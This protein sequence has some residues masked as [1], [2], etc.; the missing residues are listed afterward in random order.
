[1]SEGEKRYKPTPEMKHILDQAW[2]WVQSVPYQT[3]ARWVFYRLLQDGTYTLK[4]HYH[5]LLSLLSRAR[6]GFYQ[7]W[8]PG[9]LADDTRAPVL[10]ERLG[11]YGLA[12]RGWGFRD[13]T[14]WLKTLKKELNCPL[15]RWEIQPVYEEIWFE[16]AAMQGQFLYYANPNIPLL[17]FHGDVSI[18][19]KWRTAIRLAERCLR[20]KKPLRIF[21][22]GD[23][24]KK[25]EQIP[26]SAWDDISK[27]AFWLMQA[28][29]SKLGVDEWIPFRWESFVRVGLNKEHVAQFNMLQNPERPGTYQWEALTD[30]DAKT[31]IEKANEPLDLKTFA[32]VEAKEKEIEE[33]LKKQLGDSV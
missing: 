1:M 27:W 20:L 16:A 24:D 12:L 26:E 29:N 22:Y 19:E 9:T 6:K 7:Q 33:R 13:E 30:Q 4:A 17:A 18:P 5:H 15:D 31:L 21:Y 23:L 14:E 10:M 8:N 2:F 25:G 32:E 28:K 11:L 3:T